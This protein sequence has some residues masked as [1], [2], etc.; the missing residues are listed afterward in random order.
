MRTPSWLI[1]ATLLGCHASIDSSIDGPDPL[2][3]DATVPDVPPATTSAG[4]G[5]THA[6]GQSNQQ[7][8]IGATTRTY[9]LT[10]PI[11]YD[12]NTPLPLVFGWHGGGGSGVTL[13]DQGIVAASQDHIIAV[14]PNGLP[15]QSGATGWSLSPTGI[16]VALF[17][18]LLAN[19]ESSLCVDTSRVFSYGYSFGGFMTNLLG[20]VR[21]DVLR[22]I[23]PFHGALPGTLPACTGTVSAM[24]SNA[25]DDAT[26]AIADGVAAREAWRISNSCS[27]T[28]APVSPTPCVEYS[29]CQG[30]ERVL[31]C[32]ELSGG[33]P[34]PPDL[35]T[36]AWSF[37]SGF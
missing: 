10:L 4:C 25:M 8:V 1:V 9:I 28:S 6:G 35:A 31:W 37:L 27:P 15:V 29:G 32:L 12:P 5:M 22:A 24:L 26:V 23:A 14:H 17:D 11:N 33:H 21:G 30:Q 18:A 13:L 34:P 20:C 3:F 7:I 2:G 36:R 16:D 19:L